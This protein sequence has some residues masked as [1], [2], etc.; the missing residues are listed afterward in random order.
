MARLKENN[1]K[2]ELIKKQSDYVKKLEQE[3]KDGIREIL[4]DFE[5]ATPWS[6]WGKTR[7]EAE[8]FIKARKESG[9]PVKVVVVRVPASIGVSTFAADVAYLT[10][11]EANTVVTPDEFIKMSD[12]DHDGDKAFVYREELETK[13]EKVKDEKGKEVLDEEGNP[14]TKQFT[15]E[16]MG[17]RSDKSILFWN[18]YTQIS[19]DEIRE[20]HSEDLTTDVIK[21]I[22]EEIE[23]ETKKT[24]LDYNLNTFEDL[25]DV[26][27]K[28]SFGAK[29]IGIEAV[30]GKMLSMFT[31]SGVK[32]T[33][34]GAVYFNGKIYDKFVSDNAIELAKVLQAALD[35][36][37]DPILLKT[38]IN[39][40]TIGAANVM[41]SLGVPLKQV[42]KTL[43]SEAIGNLVKLVDKNTS[44]FSPSAVTFQDALANEKIS[45][46]KIESIDI[47]QSEFNR[48]KDSVVRIETAIRARNKKVWNDSKP[49]K[50]KENTN[51]QT[52][53]SKNGETKPI[54]FKIVDG[55]IVESSPDIK[56]EADQE[57]YSLMESFV[58][59]A[60]LSDEINQILPVIQRDNKMPNN[61]AEL[62]STKKAFNKLRKGL[63]V[64]FKPLLDR[65]LTG[66][67]ESVV[68]LMINLE[69]KHFATEKG[70]YSQSDNNMI[71]QVESAVNRYGTKSAA[72]GMVVDVFQRM[73]AQGSTKVAS[74]KQFISELP[75][76]LESLLSY[77]NKEEFKSNFDSLFNEQTGKDGI[78]VFI[79]AIIDVEQR[80]TD[81][82]SVE[83]K[84][85]VKLMTNSLDSKKEIDLAMKYLDQAR[86]QINSFSSPELKDNLFLKHI[87]VKQA[88]TGSNVKTIVPVDN[89]RK[90][91]LEVKEQIR[92]DFKKLYNTSVG[93]SIYKYQML[94]NGVSDKIGSL[95]DLM[96]E[97]ISVNFLK[98]IINN[99]IV[100]FFV[101]PI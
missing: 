52:R 20:Q 34:K 31:Q 68:D 55:N 41:L 46:A 11:G 77:Q 88:V 26:L 65:P 35:L 71:D 6:M 2:P 25:A 64:D 62:R 36:G 14:T 50:L 69:E 47:S 63:L 89:Y 43:K 57:K 13:K 82:N 1:A 44:V 53:E 100:F 72:R 79:E 27:S 75:N 45:L 3:R 86:N 32:L 99:T 95:A 38:G 12:A 49:V 98:K 90:V 81:R 4:T 42:I 16:V 37:N 83:Y 58:E 33:E 21:E 51:Y 67:Y 80:T 29:A 10:D 70:S 94:R 96:P 59:F 9:V 7:E 40:H 17:G 66:H 87:Q 15:K 93:Q 54:T 48:K 30:A 8:A 39:K 18:L 84:D 61:S 22:V 19:S 91:S 101:C 76:Q 97:E 23:G 78:D 92:N 60:N 85:A 5:V 28:Y 73:V 24:E 74:P 56:N